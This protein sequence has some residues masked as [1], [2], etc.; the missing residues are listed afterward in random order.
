[1]QKL[2]KTTKHKIKIQNTNTTKNKP[3]ITQL[4]NTTK[5]K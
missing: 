1:M 4:Q 2:P 5:I 3:K